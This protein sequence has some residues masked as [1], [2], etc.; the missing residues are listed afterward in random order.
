MG[1]GYL[2][3]YFQGYGI[4]SIL[5]TGIWDS[6]HFTSSDMGYCVQ[7]LFYFQGYWLFGE[8]NYWDICQ[9]I[10]DTYLITLRDIEH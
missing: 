3:F 7:Y 6:I 4:L 5:L 2:P 10:R 9:F 8:I 1:A